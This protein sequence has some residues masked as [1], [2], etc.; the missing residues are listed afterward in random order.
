M[1]KR[2]LNSS[3]ARFGARYGRT[4]RK[5]VSEV[6]RKLKAWHKCPYCNLK[7]VKRESMGIWKC[8]HCN[9]KFTGKSYG[10]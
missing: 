10:L 1:A 3:A 9:T 5:K 2:K 8:R 7:K 6:E 4:L